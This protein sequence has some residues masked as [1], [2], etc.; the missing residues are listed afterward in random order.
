MWDGKG[1]WFGDKAVFRRSALLLTWALSSEGQ[2]WRSQTMN[3]SF[4]VRPQHADFF[5][6]RGVDFTGAKA[7][8]W[9]NKEGTME[10]KLLLM[11]RVVS[12]LYEV[13]S[14]ILSFRLLPFPLLYF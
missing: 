12:C 2:S 6:Y 14:L 1:E 11:S 4:S 7:N 5:P 9:L 13:P 3:N 8:L 10:P